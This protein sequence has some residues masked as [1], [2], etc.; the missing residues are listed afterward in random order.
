MAILPVRLAPDPL[1]RRKAR[2]VQEIDQAVRKLAADMLETLVDAQGLGLSGN[3]VGVLRRV[4]A[5]NV[6]DREPF[7]II[8]PE[9]TSRD[10]ER[11]I[12]EGCLSFPGYFG[13]V[14]RAV[15]VTARALSVQGEK[16]QLD[17]TEVLAQALEHEIDHLN[18]ILFIDHLEAHEELW[19]AGEEPGPHEHDEIDFDEA[20]AHDRVVPPEERPESIAGADPSEGNGDG[21]GSLLVPDPKR[22]YGHFSTEQLAALERVIQEKRDELTR[23]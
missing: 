6:P 10:G 21:S 9:I 22:V 7:A 11:K 17:A 23:T 14:T 5:L 20:A 13:M 2:P 12:Q 19:K 4:V 3:Q 16:L 18:G 1:L 15:S 8:N